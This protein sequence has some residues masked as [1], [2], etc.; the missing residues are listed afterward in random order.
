[1]TLIL[2]L[3]QHWLGFGTQL[4]L[5]T[6]SKS[7]TAGYSLP[8]CYLNTSEGAKS[9]GIFSPTEDLQIQG[10]VYPPFPPLAAEKIREAVGWVEASPS[11]SLSSS[12]WN[13]KQNNREITCKVHFRTHN[14]ENH[15]T[16]NQQKAQPLCVDFFPSRG[17]N[18]F[19]CVC[20]DLFI[21]SSSKKIFLNQ[22]KE[23]KDT[24][25]IYNTIQ[26]G[27]RSYRTSEDTKRATAQ[28]IKLSDS[29]HW[30]YKPLDFEVSLN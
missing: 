15:L 8:N 20:M 21:W 7:L 27:H 26:D 5:Q 11:P 23:L 14:P 19:A 3:L 6:P 29:H 4:A 10:S 13:M 2:G 1:M 12:G 22:N 9:A 25:Y 24:L 16:V 28:L 17:D 18:V 30:R